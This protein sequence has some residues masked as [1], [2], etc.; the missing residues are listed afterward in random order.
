M[1]DPYASSLMAGPSVV[2]GMPHSDDTKIELI[3]FLLLRNK[4][5]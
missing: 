4:D 5:S 1:P 2:G 3:A